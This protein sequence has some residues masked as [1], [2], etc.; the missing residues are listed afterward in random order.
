MDALWHHGETRAGNL[1]MREKQQIMEPMVLAKHDTR[2]QPALA[3]ARNYPC[4]LNSLV[5][6]LP[7]PT[8][9]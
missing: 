6:G 1:W 4:S 3:Q 7:H 8:G 2:E 9:G 5:I